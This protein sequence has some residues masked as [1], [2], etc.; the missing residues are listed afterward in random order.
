[1]VDTGVLSASACRRHRQRRNAASS[2]TL[3]ELAID[4]QHKEGVDASVVAC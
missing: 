2:G 3:A 4:R 1:M